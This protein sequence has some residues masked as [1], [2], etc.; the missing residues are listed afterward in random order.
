MSDEGM[1]F[2]ER[3]DYCGT[4]LKME[5]RYPTSTVNGENG[6]LQIFTF[7]NEECKRTWHT[8]HGAECDR[9]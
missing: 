8:E 2:P 6:V 7:C 3:C 4:P 5:V 1:L 9:R